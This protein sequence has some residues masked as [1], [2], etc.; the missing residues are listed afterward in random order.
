MK[1]KIWALVLLFNTNFKVPEENIGDYTYIYAHIHIYLSISIYRYIL[2]KLFF[3]QKK[4]FKSL[5]VSALKHCHFRGVGGASIFHSLLSLHLPWLPSIHNSP[6]IYPGQEEHSQL[7]CFSSISVCYP[8]PLEQAGTSLAILSHH[9]HF[10]S[11]S[12]FLWST[13]T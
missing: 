1:K 13:Y 7:C 8:S 5:L 12:S 9:I 10:I 4:K 6:A 3:L 11:I 2:Q